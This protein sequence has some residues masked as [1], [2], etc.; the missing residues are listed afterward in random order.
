MERRVLVQEPQPQNYASK[1]YIFRKLK[2]VSELSERAYFSIL[3][4]CSVDP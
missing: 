3:L 1:G 4:T 2:D